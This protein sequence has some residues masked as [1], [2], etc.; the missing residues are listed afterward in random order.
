MTLCGVAF[1]SSAVGYSLVRNAQK[2]A[3]ETST[4]ELQR[5]WL[6]KLAVVTL[7]FGLAL[8]ST[9]AIE[10]IVLLPL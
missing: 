4:A 5:Y 2:A 8:V 7:V 3:L 10:A 6:S 1:L 9:T